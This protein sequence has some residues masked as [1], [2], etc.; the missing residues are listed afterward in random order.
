MLHFKC[1]H[2]RDRIE[3]NFR[4]QPVD[5]ASV[6]SRENTIEHLSFVNSGHLCRLMLKQTKR[7]LNYFI[8][9]VRLKCLVSYNLETLSCGKI[10]RIFTS[11]LRTGLSSDL[12]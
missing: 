3:F 12:W 4:R 9:C 10:K 6:T 2:S 1:F 7:Q 11:V 5:M 8:L